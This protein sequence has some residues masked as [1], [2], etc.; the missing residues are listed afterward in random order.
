MEVV[1]LDVRQIISELQEV[2]VA[3]QMTQVEAV[4]VMQPHELGAV[5]ATAELGGELVAQVWW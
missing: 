4:V 2:A 1:V 3:P 5:V